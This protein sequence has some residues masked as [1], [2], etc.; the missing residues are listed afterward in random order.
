M[1]AVGP[2]VSLEEVACAE[3]LLTL[4]AGEVLGVPDAAQRRDHLHDTPRSYT[5]LVRTV[6]L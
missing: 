2:A 1:L 5:V 6:L 4:R 3:L